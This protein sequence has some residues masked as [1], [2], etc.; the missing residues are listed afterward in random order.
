MRL[1]LSAAC[2]APPTTMHVRHKCVVSSAQQQIPCIICHATHVISQLFTDYVLC[3]QKYVCAL[4]CS[5]PAA[6]QKRYSACED[7]AQIG[8]GCCEVSSDM[9]QSKLNLPAM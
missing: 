2:R 4:C 3:L 9:H 5:R 6:I 8:V 1:I 7:T